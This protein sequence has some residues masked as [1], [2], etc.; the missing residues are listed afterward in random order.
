MI[1]NEEESKEFIPAVFT[2]DCIKE[3]KPDNP[4]F[5]EEKKR[6]QDYVDSLQQQVDFL[7]LK[8]PAKYQKYQAIGDSLMTCTYEPTQ[9]IDEEGDIINARKLIY[10]VRDYGLDDLSNEELNLL[11]RVYGIEWKKK[12]E[13]L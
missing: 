3:K 1:T 5:A 10:T 11:L 12:M 13:G 8:D 9:G 2:L 7:K 4:L 6:Q